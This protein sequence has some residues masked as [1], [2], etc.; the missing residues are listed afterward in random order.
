MA[1]FPRLSRAAIIRWYF[2]VSRWVKVPISVRPD[3]T[4]SIAT[5]PTRMSSISQRVTLNFCLPCSWTATMTLVRVPSMIHLYRRQLGVVLLPNHVATR[6]IYPS[7]KNRRPW[8][9]RCSGELRWPCM[10]AP[11]ITVDGSAT[12]IG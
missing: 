6:R 7:R 1:S 4:R 8:K 5:R 10:L 11:A 2:S 9:R 12:A 3:P